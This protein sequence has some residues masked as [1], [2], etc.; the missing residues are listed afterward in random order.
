MRVKTIKLLEEKSV[1][2]YHFGVGRGFLEMTS[3]HKEQKKQ[4]NWTLSK[5]KMFVLQRTLSTKW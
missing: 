5:L 3:K 1:N 2:L 4:I